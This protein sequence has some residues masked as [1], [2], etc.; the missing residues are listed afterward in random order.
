[1]TGISSAAQPSRPSLPEIARTRLSRRQFLGAASGLAVIAASSPLLSACSGSDRDAPGFEPIPHVL[2]GT[3]HLP[4]GYSARVL[5]RW[6]DPVLADAPGFAP[7]AQSV[8]AQAGQFGYNCDFTGY[9]KLPGSGTRGLLCVNHEY[10]IPRLMFPGLAS[11]TEALAK[12]DAARVATEMASVGVS[13][14]EIADEGQGF[15]VVAGSPYARRIHAGTPIA[16]TGPARGHARMRTPDDPAGETVLGTMANCSGAMT[17]WGTLLTAEENFN[18]NFRY[19]PDEVPDTLMAEKVNAV[20]M[21]IIAEPRS[22][23]PLFE[24]RF[25]M[26]QA[27]MEPNRFGWMVEIN[28][29]DPRSVPKKRTAMGRFKHENAAIAA[30]AQRPV[31]AYMGDDEEGEFLY[32]FVSAT[33]FDPTDMARNGDVLEAG[34]LYVAQFNVDGTGQWLKLEAGKGPL[35]PENGFHDAGD[36]AIDARRAARLLEATPT[37]RPEDV[38]ISPATGKIYVAMTGHGSRREKIPGSSRGPNPAGHILE[39]TPPLHDGKA[40]HLAD[41]FTWDLFIEAGDPASGGS[42]APRY[43]AAIA[44]SG[45]F[46]NP[47]NLV[48]DPQGRLW[49]ATDGGND[50]GIADGLWAVATEGSDRAVPRAFFACPRG[51]EACG[52]SF[53]PDGRTL[54]IAVQHPADEAGSNFDAPSTRWPDFDASLPPRPAIV[55]VTKDDGGVIGSQDVS[56]TQMLGKELV[57]FLQQA[58][59]RGRAR[60]P[61]VFAGEFNQCD[62]L[63]RSAH[64]AVHLL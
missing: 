56:A 53:T 27:P 26:G 45:W 40:D 36:V 60:H 33:P 64:G 24:K 35:H 9:L 51:A 4:K 3:H 57:E 30:E 38:E 13:I 44:P 22:A 46:A 54:F 16:L 18:Q 43:G 52:P 17:P 50:F 55:V 61:V 62:G 25:D 11:G 2:D 29:L 58:R 48:F 19:R 63:S 7:L 31:V 32:R 20:R 37:D 12:A 8:A 10:A 28:P 15:A 47:D 41:V 21:G 39:I 5:I 42:E 34:T 59:A 1:M 23:W 49:I 6:G 14:I